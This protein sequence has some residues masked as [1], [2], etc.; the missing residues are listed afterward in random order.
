MKHTH[1]SR[2]VSLVL[3]VWLVVLWGMVAVG[4]SVMGSAS[5]RGRLTV[6]PCPDAA[7]GAVFQVGV[8]L[9]PEDRTVVASAVAIAVSLVLETAPG[10]RVTHLATAPAAAGL[11]LTA[12]AYGGTDTALPVLLDGTVSLH[13]TS[14]VTAETTDGTS[15]SP[16]PL[17]LPLLH[18]TLSP[19]LGTDPETAPSASDTARSVPLTIHTGQLYCLREDTT[20]TAIPLDNAPPLS[21]PDTDTP[22]PT[23]PETDPGAETRPS[24]DTSWGSPPETG[25]LPEALP[26][27]DPPAA[28]RP[29]DSAPA[30]ILS[31]PTYLGCQ[32]TPI[33]GGAYAVRFLFRPAG[34]VAPYDEP[35]V[36][37]EG[38]GALTLEISHT[39]RVTAHTPAG[40]VAY[41]AD[42]GF[43]VCT[44]R[45]LLPGRTY[46][47]TLYTATGPI[48]VGYR[49]G[50]MVKP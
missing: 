27:P 2:L 13:T 5:E 36:V 38:G 4:G 50:A 1:F 12:G 21:V 14:A 16:D 33:R 28:V 3:G 47:F 48:E 10:Q 8:I 45:H 34:G 6:T 40:M 30:E 42:E 24:P 41:Q 11:V 20:I 46:R 43:L 49:D 31:L 18:V 25:T 26:V 32:E 9:S 39:R 22:D 23:P 19:G 29:G 44:Y 15:A 37:C 7:G 17:L 35:P